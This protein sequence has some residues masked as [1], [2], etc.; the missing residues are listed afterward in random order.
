M[1]YKKYFEDALIAGREIVDISA[2]T[3]VAVLNDLA[4]A[5]IA[6]TADLLME[7]QKDLDRMDVNDPKY[8]RL[9]LTEARIQRY[10][11]RYDECCESAESPWSYSF[12]TNHAEWFEYSKNKRAAG[13]CRRDL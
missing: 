10:C 8:D 12:G 3:I 7:N 4:E 2:E 9:K 13:R 5:A 6:Q 11:K 1:D